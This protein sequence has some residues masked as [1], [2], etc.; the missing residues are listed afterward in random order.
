MECKTF[1]E[2]LKVIIETN[3]PYPTHPLNP[4]QERRRRDIINLR[5][6]ME[7]IHIPTLER[8]LEEAPGYI[9]SDLF[10]FYEGFAAIFKSKSFHLYDQ[11]L[12]N[13]LKRVHDLFL[14]TESR[15]LST[16]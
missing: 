6:G 7:S 2:A 15:L 14:G 1:F 9:S 12:F 4:E 16:L 5:W 11:E 3:P 10:H 8:H 13:K